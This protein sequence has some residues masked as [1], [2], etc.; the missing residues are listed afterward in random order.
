MQ[1]EQLWVVMAVRRVAR[2]PEMARLGEA[3][4]EG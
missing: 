1:G 2:L 3:E 4:E